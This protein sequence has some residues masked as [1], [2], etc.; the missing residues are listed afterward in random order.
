MHK[1]RLRIPKILPIFFI[2]NSPQIKHFLGHKGK[3]DIGIPAN[4]PVFF[5]GT[6][7]IFEVSD[8][9]KLD[10]P[11]F[12]EVLLMKNSTLKTIKIV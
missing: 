3:E 9:K 7:H 11:V 10:C 2:G 8:S 12:F 1:R 5:S 4:C 6:V